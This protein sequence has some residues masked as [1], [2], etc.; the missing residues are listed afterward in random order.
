MTAPLRTAAGDAIDRSK[1]IRFTFDGT[2][3]TGYAGD[4][5][6]SALLANGIHLVGRSF[7]YH[8]PRGILSAGSEE[9]NALVR[10]GLEGYS[11]SN[12]RATMVEL[13]DGLTAYSQNAWP[14]LRWDMGAINNRISRFFPAGFYYKTFL[15]SAA[16][17]TRIFEPFIRKMAG[18]GPA[19]TKPDPDSY[20][21]RH[22]HCDLLVI[23][24]GPAGLSAATAAVASGARV[25]LVDENARVGGQLRASQSSIDGAKAS[26]W[27]EATAATIKSAPGCRVLSRTTAFGV[28]DNA[29]VMAVERV[30]DHRGTG[31]PGP[32]Q[33]LWQIRARHIIV[34]AGAHEQ[35]LRFINNDLPGIMLASA[36]R[37]Y[38]EQYGVLTG[39]QIILLGQDEETRALLTAAGAQVTQ[40]SRET[41]ISK[42]VGGNRVS[43]LLIRDAQGQ[44]QK[45]KCDCVLMAGPW[46]P[47][48]HL[49]SQAGG[50]T[51]YDEQAKAFLPV[52]GP[53]WLTSAGS[54]RTPLSTAQ[55]LIDGRTVTD[56]ILSD[57]GYSPTAISRPS[58]HDDGV[59]LA[60]EVPVEDGAKAFI[61]YQNDVTTADIDLAYREGFISVEHL[62]RYTT[63]GMATDQGKLSNVAALERMA[64]RLNVQPGAVGTTTFRPPYTPVTFG[65]LAAHDSGDLLDP[66]RETAMHGW[67][68]EQGAEFE[69]VGQWKRPYYYPRSGETMDDAVRRECRAVRE[70]V[71]MLDAST[72]GKIDIQGPDAVRFLERIYTNAWAKLEIGRCR[73][74]VM[75]SEDGMVMDDGVTARI[76]DDRF[77]TFTTTGNAA[78]VL[79]HMEDYLQT[80]WPDLKVYLTSVTEHWAASV[81]TGPRSRDV[82]S[83]VVQGIDFE[84]DSFPHLAWREG[85]IGDVPVRVYRISFTGEMSYEVH[86]PSPSGRAVW[87][88]LY[89]AG[90]PFGITAY[91]TETMHVL[92]A[93]KGYI[94]IGQETDGT[95]S[96]V[97][98]GLNWAISKKKPD[99]IGKRS[100][101]RPD[102]KRTDRKQLVGLVPSDRKTCLEEG[103]QIAIMPMQQAPHPM[104]GHVTSAYWS[105]ILQTPFA[106]ALVKDGR[107]SEGERVHAH[108][109]G[110][111]IPCEVTKAVFYD[112]A[113]E[114]MN[115]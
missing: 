89:K 66:I 27:A 112:P 97:D 98:L 63:T 114:N 94:I 84:N 16:I 60:A 108:F 74:G 4:T 29:L 81:V 26:T 77:I 43:A 14:S 24:A 58:C 73:Y 75:C 2:S 83:S 51:V 113:G 102:M 37:L 110:K 31:V 32:R 55:C 56:R 28:Y 100:L 6:A 70:S 105:E 76:A 104:I 23:G 17:W 103:A 48:V 88:A 85:R 5:L 106:L 13:Y 40:L 34:A 90:E 107:Q 10:V 96:P 30:S 78:H 8:R 92:R 69:N 22:A 19:P 1:S 15:G 11:E 82:V 68:I 35:P 52:G 79:D 9:P 67:H 45:L 44:K 65:T 41:T 38:L 61:D 59:Q 72:L 33:R 86:C 71:G 99:F 87:E 101:A 39:R 95:V 91:G 62:K 49:H 20:T 57:L 115:G 25:I 21:K 42:A 50:K 36:A 111:V 12:A 7:K 3:Y 47:A 80:E 109:D 46:Q 18:L 93:E 64:Q 54:C 53:A